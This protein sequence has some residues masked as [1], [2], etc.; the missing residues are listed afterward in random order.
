[1][2]WGG[3]S[4]WPQWNF[5]VNPKR[6]PTGPACPSTPSS[7]VGLHPPRVCF[8]PLRDGEEEKHEEPEEVKEGK[9]EEEEGKRGRREQ[10]EGL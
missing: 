5:H 2:A 7:H 9:E 4:V 10:R 6:E 1:M 8:G 3:C